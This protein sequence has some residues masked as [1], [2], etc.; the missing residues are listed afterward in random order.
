MTAAITGPTSCS[1]IHVEAQLRQGPSSLSTLYL[2]SH[3]GRARGS[4]GGLFLPRVSEW[5][6]LMAIG[7]GGPPPEPLYLSD[8]N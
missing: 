2:I 1:G 8:D 7:Y 3:E 4:G 5:L 6:F